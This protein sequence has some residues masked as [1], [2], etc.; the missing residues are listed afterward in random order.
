MTGFI[1]LVFDPPSLYRHSNAAETTSHN[2]VAFIQTPSTSF[3]GSSS[4]IPTRRLLTPEPYHEAASAFAS[5]LSP[6][7]SIQPTQAK[8]RPQKPRKKILKGRIIPRQ[9]R[10]KTHQRTHFPKLTETAHYYWPEQ[11][12]GQVV[13]D[14]SAYKRAVELLLHLEFGTLEQAIAS[15]ARWTNEVNVGQDWGFEVVGQLELPAQ[16]TV[17]SNKGAINDLSGMIK[18][19]KRMAADSN[20][21]LSTEATGA[22]SVNNLADGLVR[23]KAKVAVDTLGNEGEP[24]VNTLGASLVRKKI[25]PT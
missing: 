4:S 22:A 7:N 17:A 10:I 23:K 9:P 14:E 18:Q 8:I 12:R 11:G 13:L 15:S 6:L 16:T 3:S 19:K 21:D 25:K 2:A 24:K 5:V 20:T 1:W